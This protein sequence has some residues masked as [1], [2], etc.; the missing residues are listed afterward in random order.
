MIKDWFI[1]RKFYCVIGLGGV[2]P[3]ESPKARFLGK[4]FTYLLLL[5]AI[6]LLFEWQ[7]QQVGYQDLHTWW[8]FNWV[9]WGCFFGVFITL[10]LMV[11]RNQRFVRENWLLLLVILMGIPF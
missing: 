10:L 9:I 5:L 4:L 3:E 11:R 2:H 7:L 1:G 8:I 6:A